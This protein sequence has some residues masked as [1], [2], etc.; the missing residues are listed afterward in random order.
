[1]S[2]Q[3]LDLGIHRGPSQGYAPDLYT[4]ALP[5]KVGWRKNNLHE[6][7]E[8]RDAATLPHNEISRRPGG[9]CA[10]VPR[11][12]AP[13]RRP[14]S[15]GARGSFPYRIGWGAGPVLPRAAE[16]SLRPDLTVIRDAEESSCRCEAPG[17]QGI[18]AILQAIDR[19]LLTKQHIHKRQH[20][21]SSSSR[22]GSPRENHRADDSRCPRIL[23]RGRT[24]PLMTWLMSD[25]RWC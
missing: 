20:L 23:G 19:P 11:I 24:A 7:S 14:T 10:R 22:G 8:F 15:E 9:S 12:S 18:N 6:P 5:T 17:T 2:L 25:Q 3:G 13:I 1:M 21:I 4:T 16:G